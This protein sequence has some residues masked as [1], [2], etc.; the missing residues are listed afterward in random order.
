MV[1]S[2]ACWRH[3]YLGVVRIMERGKQ[4]PLLR[5]LNETRPGNFV[6]LSNEL[7][8]EVAISTDTPW[9]GSGGYVGDDTV[10]VRIEGPS[11]IYEFNT[12]AFDLPLVVTYSPPKSSYFLPERAPRVNRKHCSLAADGTKSATASSARSKRLA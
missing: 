5:V 9:S 4:P 10:S 12:A 2:G 6:I 8:Y 3:I 1:D 11:G 7:R